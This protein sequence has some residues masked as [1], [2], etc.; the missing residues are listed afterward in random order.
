M[1]A[2]VTSHIPQPIS[3]WLADN[4]APKQISLQPPFVFPIF[5]LFSS[6]FAVRWPCFKNIFN[7][8]ENIKFAISMK[9]LRWNCLFIFFFENYFT[10][11]RI[12]FCFCYIFSPNP[13]NILVIDL[14]SFL[15]LFSF[16]FFRY[17]ISFF[18]SPD[19]LFMS[20]YFQRGKNYIFFLSSFLY[21]FIY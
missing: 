13:F 14:L 17:P 7:I 3:A 18:F 15:S 9:I 20:S 12:S 6:L 11:I 1:G 2:L 16:F 21:P 4:L 10:R 5:N 19:L 8:F